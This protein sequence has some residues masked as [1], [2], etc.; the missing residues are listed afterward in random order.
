MTRHILR[1]V[2][3]ALILAALFVLPVFAQSTPD[4]TDLPSVVDYLATGGAAIVAAVVVSWLAEKLPAFK[5]WS[6]TAKWAAQVG[7]SALLG[8]GA[9]YLINYQPELLKQLA[10]I[11]KAVVLAVAPAI[12]NQIWHAGQKMLARKPAA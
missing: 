7:L 11:F 9:W 5:A 12:V 6:A 1:A 3:L 10:P 8:V 2:T 4:P